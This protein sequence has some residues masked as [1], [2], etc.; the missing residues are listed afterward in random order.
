[1]GA[2]L[3]TERSVASFGIENF[4]SPEALYSLLTKD[5]L[6]HSYSLQTNWTK[7]AEPGY[8][9]VTDVTLLV[10]C[11]LKAKFETNSGKIPTSRF[12]KVFW[13]HSDI[14]LPEKAMIEIGWF[15][16]KFSPT[17][18]EKL[19]DLGVILSQTL[20]QSNNINPSSSDISSLQKAGLYHL[21]H[22]FPESGFY[23]SEPNG[24]SRMAINVVS[25][26]NGDNP[27]FAL[28]VVVPWLNANLNNINDFAK[29]QNDHLINTE[30]VI[31]AIYLAANKELPPV[32]LQFK[33]EQEKS[34]EFI[35]E[36]TYCRSNYF[37]A[38]SLT[39]PHCGAS[40][41]M[42]VIQEQ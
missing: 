19:K 38:E 26:Q 21:C 2:E 5:H 29:A 16:I 32:K 41:P 1:M 15:S 13:F 3:H 22:N 36:C 37:T 14:W 35:A 27:R 6:S 10:A 23:V 31:R 39:C 20:P 42:F 24:A 12:S 33:A 8:D 4:Y 30:K 18:R 7:I 17:I 40:K 28:R 11:D 9:P 25:N 34:K